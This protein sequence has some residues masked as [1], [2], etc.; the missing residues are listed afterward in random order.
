M[1]CPK[2]KKEI[3]EK[4]LRCNHCSSKIASICKDCGAYNSIYNLKCVN[5]NKELLKLCP[6]CKGINLPDAKKCRKCEYD[7]LKPPKNTKPEEKKPQETPEKSI[8]EYD[9]ELC[10]QQKAKKLLL[11]GLLAND[12]KIISLNGPQGAGKSIVVKTVFQELK[13]KEIVWLFGECSEITQLSPCGLIQDILLTFFNVPNF[14]IDGPKLKKDSQKFFQSEFPSLN[15]EEVFNL[16]NIL[17]PTNLEY[18]E[19]ILKNKEKT[20]TI[21]NKVFKTILE[22]NKAII[23]VEKFDLIDGFSYEFLHNLI[24]TDFALKS[25]KLLLTYNELRPVRGFL[26]CDKL[27]NDAYLDIPLGL[28][29]QNQVNSFIDQ[30]FPKEK[31]PEALKKEL[32][33]LSGRNPAVLEQFVNLLNDFKSLNNSFEIILPKTFESAV[34]MRLEFIK[35]KSVEAYKTVLLAAV[36][37]IKFSPEI[38]NQI[39]KINE[40]DFVDILNYLREINFIIPASEHFYSFKNSMLWKTVFN[41]AKE[42]EEFK[43]FNNALF[44][45]YSNYTV[46]TNSIMAI[47]AQNLNQNLSALG[48]WTDNT[49]LASAI[50]DTNLYAIS[51]KQSL[52]LIDKLEDVKNSF[53]KNNIYERL[54]K[55]LSKN[56]PK[57]AME[58]LPKAIMNAQQNSDTLKEIELTGYLA[59]CCISLGNYYGTI[60]CINS[61]IARLDDNLD[62]ELAM[63]KSRKLDALLN[64]GNSGEIINLADNEILPYFDKYIDAKPHKVISIKDLYKAWL[65][66]YLI[67]ANALA[68]QGNNRVFE[69]LSTLFDLFEKNE[70]DNE[71]FICKAK[72]TLAL[73]NTMKGDIETSA[74][75][76]ED[77]IKA[78]KTDIMDNETISKWNLINILN[79]FTRKNYTGLKEELF[80][81]VTFANNVNDNFTKNILKTLLGKIFKD[82]E[83]AKRALDI[84]SEQ[85]TYFSK[86]K[87]AIGA[88]L[89]WLLIAEAKLIVEGPEESLDVA[90]KA[91]DVAQNP[92]INNYLFIILYNKVIAEAYMAQSDYEMAKIHIEKA[93]MIARKFELLNLLSELYL[94]YGK[95][96]QDIAIVKKE[97]QLDYIQG[98]SKMYKKAGAIANGIKNKYLSEKIEKAKEVLNSFCKLNGIN[99]SD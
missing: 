69:V 88:L 23:I 22:R 74:K 97:A 56:N 9:K 11:E 82:E 90:K 3:P 50:G 7:F 17:Y 1:K 71:L 64:I 99:L 27:N 30:Y 47:F 67:L 62:L 55:L 78:Y 58:Y 21:L 16:L 19:D 66:T 95:Y 92:K 43:A 86:E 77:I 34:K 84:Y 79:N 76:L 75:I 26:Y 41:I 94:L 52:S 24:N 12:K 38:L 59:N 70:F 87:N 68:F 35:E 48:S 31:C 81:V 63:L 28:F 65:Q 6:S 10:S 73:A 61:V 85:I 46:S 33:Q 57:E 36:Q 39:L 2:C 15:N 32:F 45:V 91:L 14:C 83:N 80:Q 44:T 51:Q 25:L 4:T 49:K 54:G 89:T 98:A 18:F 42:S 5:C 40:K 29:H 20:F 96:L 72:L 53:V 60:E 13:D 8:I 37:G 93:I